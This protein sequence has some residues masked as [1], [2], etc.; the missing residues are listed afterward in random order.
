[1]TDNSYETFAMESISTEIAGVGHQ[2]LPVLINNRNTRKRS[3]ICLIST[4]QT[5]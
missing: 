1:M 5:L 4:I 2:V 3:D